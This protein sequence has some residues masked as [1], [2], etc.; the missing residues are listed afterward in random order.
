MKT[1]LVIV[2]CVVSLLVG[3]WGG[4]SIQSQPATPPVVNMP[5]SSMGMMHRMPDGTMM[6]GDMASMMQQMNAGLVGKQGDEFDKAFIDEMIIHHQGA[7]EM[8]KMVLMQ[9]NRSELKD[10]AQAIITAQTQEID[11]MTQWRKAWFN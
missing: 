8:A 7:V 10:L 3:V 2:L 1:S 11:Q 6:G 9:S 5:T 4:Y